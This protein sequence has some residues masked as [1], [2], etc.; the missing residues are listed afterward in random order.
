MRQNEGQVVNED[1]QSFGGAIAFIGSV[2]SSAKSLLLQATQDFVSQRHR[3]FSTSVMANKGGE[4][5]EG[6]CHVNACCT[7]T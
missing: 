6:F 3:A 4:R 5:R 1:R 2:V 7:H